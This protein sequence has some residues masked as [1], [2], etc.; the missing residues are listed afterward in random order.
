[1]SAT[2]ATLT[3]SEYEERK[4]FMDELKK[5][6]PSEQQQ[7]FRILKKGENEYS[8][9][10]NGVFFDISKVSKESFE[11]M[12]TFIVFCQENRKEFEVRDKEM[13]DSRLN[14]GNLTTLE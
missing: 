14:I 12:K 9:N 5:L 2:A 8:E 1:M 6:V 10:T 11:D 3:D 13:E 7:I 4:N